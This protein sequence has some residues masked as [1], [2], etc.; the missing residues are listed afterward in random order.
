MLLGVHVSVAPSKA[1][2][3]G[4]VEWTVVVIS[5]GT[6]T[7]RAQPSRRGNARE[8]PSLARVG[9]DRMDFSFAVIARNMEIEWSITWSFEVKINILAET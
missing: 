2:S 8:H 1:V 9:A 7:W 4:T 5:G 3:R 6:S